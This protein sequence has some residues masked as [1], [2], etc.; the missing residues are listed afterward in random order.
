MEGPARIWRH[1]FNLVNV[2]QTLRFSVG[3][4]M[5]SPCP[6][7]GSAVRTPGDVYGQLFILANRDELRQHTLI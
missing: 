3:V 5:V 7:K 4:E 2:L 1:D 6:L